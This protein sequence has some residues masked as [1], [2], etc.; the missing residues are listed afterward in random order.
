MTLRPRIPVAE[1]IG[2]G[3]SHKDDPLGLIRDAI[4]VT[5][6][7]AK[8]SGND[9]VRVVALKMLAHLSKERRVA[10]I[11]QYR[12]PRKRVDA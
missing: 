10:K 1:R 3:P 8:V 5:Y 9:S 4:N 7:G 12:T 6:D 11:P 2:V